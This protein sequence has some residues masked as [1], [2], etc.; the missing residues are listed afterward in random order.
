MH[1]HEICWLV[2]KLCPTFGNPMDCVQPTRLLYPQNSPSKNTGVGSHSLL[3]EIFPSQRSNMGLLHCRLIL[4]WLSHQ[5][6]Q[7]IV[8]AQLM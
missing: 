1:V 2:A 4:D 7:N 3:Q 8:R 5:G 6:P